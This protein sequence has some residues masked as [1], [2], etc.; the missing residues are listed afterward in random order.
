MFENWQPWWDMLIMLG[1]GV[2]IVTWLT[3]KGEWDDD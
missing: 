2:I 1:A 3:I